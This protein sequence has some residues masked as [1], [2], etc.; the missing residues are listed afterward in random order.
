MLYAKLPQA[1][2]LKKTLPIVLAEKPKAHCRYT[3]NACGPLQVHLKCM[4]YIAYVSSKCMSLLIY[5]SD[6]C[7]Q[8]GLRCCNVC[9]PSFTAWVALCRSSNSTPAMSCM[10]SACICEAQTSRLCACITDGLFVPQKCRHNAYKCHAVLP[11][12]M[13]PP[14]Y[15]SIA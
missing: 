11:H 7:G 6:S 4:L 3:S 13:Q 1:V 2:N 9:L 8:S 10:H 12:C 5:N 14:V 15:C